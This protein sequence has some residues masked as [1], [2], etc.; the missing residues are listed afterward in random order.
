MTA[1]P[2]VCVVDDDASVRES[3][4]DLLKALGFAARVFSSAEAFLAAEGAQTTQC[5][6]LDVAMPGMSGPE[7]QQEIVRR[8]WTIPI[9]YITASTDAAERM[10]LLEQGA[11]TC[12]GKP[13]GE[14]E[15]VHALDIALGR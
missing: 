9:V 11:V 3:L 4:P 2:R 13:F 7:L 12:L 1:Q 15:L 5:L 8:K 6:L 14:A 10:H